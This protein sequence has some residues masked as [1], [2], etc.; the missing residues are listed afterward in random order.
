MPGPRRHRVKP[1]NPVNLR[2]DTLPQWIS[3]VRNDRLARTRRKQH[4]N[5]SG[6]PRHPGGALRHRG[7]PASLLAA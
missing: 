1:G 5:G 4:M 7:K 6:R 3:H 2:L